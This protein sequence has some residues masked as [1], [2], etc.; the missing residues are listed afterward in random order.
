LQK[1]KPTRF[2]IRANG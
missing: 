1:T 2:M